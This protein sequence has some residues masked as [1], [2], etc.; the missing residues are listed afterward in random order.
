MP[1]LKDMEIV[2]C[3]AMKT[4]LFK[5]FCVKICKWRSFDRNNEEICEYEVNPP[6]LL[7]KS[8]DLRTFSGN[9]AFLHQKEKE[10]TKMRKDLNELKE[11]SEK[12][13]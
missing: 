6:F 7:V 5:L 12:K 13:R 10:L 9:Q 3:P 1:K 2:E 4:H 11:K 8:Q